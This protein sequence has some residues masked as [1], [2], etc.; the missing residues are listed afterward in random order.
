M[1]VLQL[2]FLTIFI[3]SFPEFSKD[4]FFSFH[5][6]ELFYTVNSDSVYVQK[7]FNLIGKTGVLL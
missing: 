3:G 2:F 1:L 6:K 5:V 7:T 4:S